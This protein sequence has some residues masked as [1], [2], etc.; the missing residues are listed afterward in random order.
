MRIGE[1]A[2][3]LPPVR[4]AVAGKATGV[5]AEAQVQVSEVAFDV[6]KAMRIDHA[7]GGTGEIVVE[8]FLRVTRVESANAKQKSQ[9]FLVFGVD[10]ED[11]IERIHEFVA[12]VRDNAKLSI[13]TS[14]FAQRE[15]FASFATAQ[16]MPLQELG[17]HGHTDAET[18]GAKFL[19]DLGSRKIGPKRTFLIGIAGRARIDD[20]QECFVEARP[21]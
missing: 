15:C 1:S 14:M 17:N 2:V 8:S 12:V 9:E 18:Q 21:E 10:A 11:R 16:T 5:V 6:V 3:G 4:D 13:A 19:S 7:P 20:F